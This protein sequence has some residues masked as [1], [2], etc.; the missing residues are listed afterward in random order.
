MTLRYFADQT[1]T[2]IIRN[3]DTEI[4]LITQDLDKNIL[5]TQLK[6][7]INNLLFLLLSF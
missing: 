1:M 7:K 5:K 2:Q 6:V 3:T 4:K